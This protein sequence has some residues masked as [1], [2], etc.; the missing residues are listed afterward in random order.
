MQ[1]CGKADLTPWVD[2]EGF[3]DTAL[4]M[5]LTASADFI[6]KRT[7]DQFYR[8]TGVEKQF[9][10]EG[11]GLLLVEP[12]LH[13]VTA[14]R[15]YDDAN[16]TIEETLQ[17]DEYEFG[18]GW[19]KRRSFGLTR[20]Y[21]PVG[22]TTVRITGDWGWSEVPPLIRLVAAR[23]SAAFLTGHQPEDI[24]SEGLGSY[25][26]AY[27]STQGAGQGASDFS[28]EGILASFKLHK[29]YAGR[30]RG[31]GPGMDDRCP[32]QWSFIGGDV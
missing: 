16:W 29:I 8:E 10:G 2:P 14:I 12:S 5:A 24:S 17:S 23:L 25:S 11:K 27:R 4:K 9:D 6:H 21:F 31:R 22:R 30:V 13:A 3:N 26:V 32:R 15:L 1:Y 18:P 20:R 7:G 19:V 28:I